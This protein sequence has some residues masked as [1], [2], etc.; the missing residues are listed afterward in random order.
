MAGK[1]GPSKGTGGHGRRKLSGK[2]PTPK[3]EERPGHP[4]QR[5]ARSATKRS[6]GEPSARA[7]RPSRGGGPLPP[8]ELVVGRNAVVEALRAGVPALSLHV[9]AGLD[10]DERMAEIRA[11]AEDRGVPVTDA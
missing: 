9:A 5:R 8:E 10:R 6:G 2:G 11:L 7:T 3:A 4:A 1:K